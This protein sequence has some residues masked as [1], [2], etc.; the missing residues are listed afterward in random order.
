M[1]SILSELYTGMM[2]LAFDF[3]VYKILTI[4]SNYL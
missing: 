4:S 3:A 1:Q 2:L